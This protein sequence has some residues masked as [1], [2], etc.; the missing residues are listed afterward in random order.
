MTARAH[1][2]SALER[3]TERLSDPGRGH[4]EARKPFVVVVEP[5]P[6]I[7]LHLSDLL[8]GRYEVLVAATE[9]DARNLLAAHVGEIEIILIDISLNSA[10]GGLR[11]AKSLR[12]EASWRKVPIIATMACAL[13]ENENRV[14]A[15]GC[16]GYLVKPLHRK[17]RSVR[18]EDG[19][20]RPCPTPSRRWAGWRTFSRRLRYALHVS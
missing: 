5:D 13:P 7:R 2:Q 19:P 1:E 10:D 18:A 14:L 15:A 20:F 4:R 17:E 6:A 11:L 8:N 12:E 9:A 16:N 3:T